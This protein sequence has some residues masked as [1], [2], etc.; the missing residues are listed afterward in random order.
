MEEKIK[1]IISVIRVKNDENIIKYFDFNESEPNIIRTG[2]PE[3]DIIEANF[4][5]DKH[6]SL[7]NVK[8]T[9]INELLTLTKDK[10]I[11]IVLD[12][13]NDKKLLAKKYLSK[14]ISA[15]SSISIESRI[16]PGNIIVISNN[17]FNFINDNLKEYLNIVKYD[18]D[19][20]DYKISSFD[21][22]IDERVNDDIIVYRKHSGNKIYKG[23]H[24]LLSYNNLF[25]IAKLGDVNT[26]IKRLRIKV[27]NNLNNEIK[28]LL[29]KEIYAIKKIPLDNPYEE[30]INLIY[31]HIHE[32]GSKV[33][34]SGMG[35][36]GQVGLNI[37]T[38]L[39]STGTPAIY[40]HA[41]EAQ[42][43]DMG[44]IQK[45][46]VLF[47]ISN[48][49]KTKEVIEFI[50]LAHNLYSDLK[51]IVLIGN[52]DSE[53]V[54]LA[55]FVLYT[56]EQEE[57]CPLGLTPTASTTAMMVIGDIIVVQLM[58]KINFTKE[59]YSK[60]HHGGYLGEKSK[61]N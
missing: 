38:T 5:C 26:N 57:L 21:V 4:L 18:N 24:L 29:D 52:L 39:S 35:K 7:I 55:N 54:K 9:L 59:D 31:K 19:I 6:F 53:L 10:N 48:S 36:A 27:K 28:D 25:T 14:I 12:D 34:I 40:I 8:D 2:Y 3:L 33:V 17:T 16:G 11:D 50:H 23:I 13:I 22:I 43:G 15:G 46:D 60:R 41:A 51:V 37:A 49:G 56:G 58:K 30:V 32:L 1:Q 61:N 44:M 42:H 45:N 47:L 20:I